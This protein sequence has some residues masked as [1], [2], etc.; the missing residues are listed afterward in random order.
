MAVAKVGGAANMNVQ[1]IVDNEGTHD[2]AAW[3]RRFPGAL[4]MLFVKPA[5]SK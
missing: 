5:G 2:E 1:A 4:R 3:A